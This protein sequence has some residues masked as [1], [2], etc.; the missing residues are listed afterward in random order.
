MGVELAGDINR[1]CGG[2][3]WYATNTAAYGWDGVARRGSWAVSGN[4]WVPRVG[5]ATSS[6]P[7]APKISAAEAVRRGEV[8]LGSPTGPK[9]GAP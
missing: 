3:V 6:A 2:D 9:A 8:R 7:A 5:F 1:A 4:H